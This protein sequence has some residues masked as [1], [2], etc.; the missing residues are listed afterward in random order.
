MYFATEHT[1]KIYTGTERTD[2]MYMYT[3]AGGTQVRCIPE[4]EVLR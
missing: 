1:G 3:E 2:K 4:L